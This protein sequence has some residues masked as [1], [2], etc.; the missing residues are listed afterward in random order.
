MA[1]IQ[2]PMFWLRT[3][4]QLG[5]YAL[6]STPDQ[7]RR[8]DQAATQPRGFL[9]ILIPFMSAPR[10]YLGARPLKHLK[11]ATAQ[12]SKRAGRKSRGLQ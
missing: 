3:V 4:T 10:L 7:A 5:P 1:V 6:D 2:V 12:I 9:A 8:S 11:G